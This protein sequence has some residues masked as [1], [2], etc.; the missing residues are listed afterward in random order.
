MK[1]L[2]D[3][4]RVI[5]CVEVKSAEMN[6][7]HKAPGNKLF[8]TQALAGA[9]LVGSQPYIWV[10]R[11]ASYNTGHHGHRYFQSPVQSH[12]LLTPLGE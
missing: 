3:R 1:L 7:G 2:L 12:F 10:L 9:S 4:R 8:F 6:K 5:K 11:G